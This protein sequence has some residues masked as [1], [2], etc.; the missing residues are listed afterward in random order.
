ML[1]NPHLFWKGVLVE[2][3]FVLIVIVIGKS[4]VVFLQKGKF[5]CPHWIPHYF[6]SFQS[7]LERKPPSKKLMS[8]IASR[9]H[10]LFVD[11]EGFAW[12][13]GSNHQY[14]LGLGEKDVRKEPVRIQHLPPIT[15]VS[16]STKYSMFLASNGSVWRSGD[17]GVTPGVAVHSRRPEIIVDLPFIKSVTCGYRHSLLLEEDGTVWAQGT[18]EC[19]QLGL[20]DTTE[21][22]NPTKLHDLPPIVSIACGNTNTFLI[23][24]DGNLWGC[25]MI[26]EKLIHKPT[27]FEFKSP[28]ASV[29]LGYEYGLFLDTDG[30]VWGIGRNDHGQ[31]G[32][33][34]KF[35]D[36]IT[37]TSAENVTK[38]SKIF[39]GFSHSFFVTEDEVWGMG[40]NDYGQIAL[41]NLEGVRSVFSPVKID[42]LSLISSIAVGNYSSLFLD[43]NGSVW[44]C[45]GN[46]DGQ[47][48]VSSIPM[49][50]STP[51]LIPNLPPIKLPTRNMRMKSARNL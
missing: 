51:Q 25:G 39:A 19:G 30:K 3:F 29:S 4:T 11:D 22:P 46:M 7:T 1:N 15:S 23:D 47:L 8:T 48:G 41:S 40:Q 17:I 16:C 6:R 24:L 37:K 2:L 27:I 20:Q 34:E 5:F 21:R 12:G 28:I 35:V 43:Y 44:S 14:Q 45:G 49:H 33:T 10:S 42:S 36:K 50:V 26:A 31:I 9:N 32:Q 38:I 13:C 18:N